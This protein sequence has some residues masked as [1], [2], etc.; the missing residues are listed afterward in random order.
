MAGKTLTKKKTD[1]LFSTSST[2]EK[3][4]LSAKLS[5]KSKQKQLKKEE[6]E[7]NNFQNNRE[8]QRNSKIGTYRKKQIWYHHRCNVTKHRN[9]QWF[10]RRWR[11]L[12]ISKK[13]SKALI[14]G[15]CTN[16]VGFLMPN[17]YPYIFS[18]SVFLN[19]CF[20]TFYIIFP[21]DIHDI[22]RFQ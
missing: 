18:S 2:I 19:S 21:N 6:K 1:E 5:A 9:W 16:L 22:N 12:F 15:L 11:I 10:H 8:I 17:I 7:K 13:N 20:Q 4:T 3:N 14:S